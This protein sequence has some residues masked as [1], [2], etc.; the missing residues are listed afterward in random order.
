[1]VVILL[2]DKLIIRC[3]RMGINNNNNNN[4]NNNRVDQD[5]SI[6][7]HNRVIMEEYLVVNHSIWVVDRISSNRVD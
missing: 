1:M 5:Y 4:N 3:F 7:R 6:V 2:L